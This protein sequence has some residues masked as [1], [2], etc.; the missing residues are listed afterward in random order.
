MR[1]NK[2]EEA[3][4]SKTPQKKYIVTCD[5]VVTED[6]NTKTEVLTFLKILKCDSTLVEEPAK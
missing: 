2:K 1:R 5:S 6:I 3:D 4:A